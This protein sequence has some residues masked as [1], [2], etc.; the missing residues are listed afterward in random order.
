M[1][2]TLAMLKAA[3]VHK[4]GEVDDDGM[5]DNTTL[6]INAGLKQM[7]TEYDWPWLITEDTFV[8]VGGQMDYALPANCTR[9]RKL[10]LD[11][12]VFTSVQYD[13]LVRYTAQNT[14]QPCLLY[15]QNIT[16]KIAPIPSGVYTITR[17]FV[18]PENVLSSDADTI[19]CPDWY[20]DLPAIYGALEE[21]RRR[22][23]QVMVNLL[24][25]SKAEWIQRIRD[26]IAKDKDLPD[27]LTRNDW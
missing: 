27:I 24:E 20:N 9:L 26:N 19:L 5:L 12:D 4:L 25:S 17:E 15:I 18:I 2:T 8:T 11:G 21:A 16:L 13:E 6:S 1:A 7:A 22:Q 10:I 23:D 14:G 3:V